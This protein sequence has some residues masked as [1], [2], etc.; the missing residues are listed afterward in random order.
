MLYIQSLA[1]SFGGIRALKGVSLKIER[2]EMVGII[3]PNGS[4][5]TTLINLITG[6][7]K[8][9]RGKIYFNNKDITGLPPHIICKMGIMR[10]YQIPQPFGSMSVYDNVLIASEYCGDGDENYVKEVLKELNLWNKAFVLAE[11]LSLVE[12]RILEFA[13]AIATKPKL[14]LIDEVLA[15]LRESEISLISKIINDLNRNEVTI[16]WVEHRVH[17]LIKIVKRLIVLNFGE[18]IA[19]DAPEKVL[20]DDRVIEAYLGKLS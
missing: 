5:K 14:L 20:S 7:Y 3:G 13:R 16:L 9:D 6:I 15:G 12:K 8:P 18:I 2:G 4:G 10:T 1:K 11:S 19:D 17:E